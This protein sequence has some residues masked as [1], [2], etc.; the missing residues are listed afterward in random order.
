MGVGVG[1]CAHTHTLTHAV[2]LRGDCMPSDSRACALL[3]R[4]SA[5]A[6]GTVGAGA[7]G[8]W[9]CRSTACVVGA[10]PDALEAV[11]AVQASQAGEES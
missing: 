2:V 10:L 7:P 6:W 1:T 4:P 11:L 8:S 9:W 5:R 3:G